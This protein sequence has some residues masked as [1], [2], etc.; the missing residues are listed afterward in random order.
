MC[1]CTRTFLSIKLSHFLPSV[2]SPF[3]GK[4]FLVGLKRK[5]LDSTIYF[6]SSPPNQTHSK[7]IFL[8]IFS[9]KLSIYL[10]SPS[11][12]QTLSKLT[13][14]NYFFPSLAIY[15]L[16]T[17]I[18]NSILHHYS[19]LIV[20]PIFLFIHSCNSKIHSLTQANPQER[21]NIN[22]LI[23]LM[24]NSLIEVLSYCSFFG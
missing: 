22:Y 5:H 10:I 9:P 17:P 21:I 6:P 7:K 18:S 12:K 15:F 11:N 20:L 4:N 1:K 13:Q 24:N 3:W 14:K 16:Y 2:F 19:N 23:L 8:P